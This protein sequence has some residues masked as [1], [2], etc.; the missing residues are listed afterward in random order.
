MYFLKLAANLVGNLIFAMT[1]K[2]KGHSPL[3]I[4]HVALE[5]TISTLC[6]K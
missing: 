3:G 6:D 5:M 2:N 4:T 1:S